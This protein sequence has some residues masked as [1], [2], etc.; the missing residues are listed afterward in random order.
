MPLSPKIARSILLPLRE[1]AMMPCA[2]T[3]LDVSFKNERTYHVN[4]HAVQPLM[5][6]GENP[7]CLLIESW[8]W[9]WDQVFREVPL[10]GPRV[11]GRSKIGAL[12]LIP[13]LSPSYGAYEGVAYIPNLEG[14]IDYLEDRTEGSHRGGGMGVD[15]K[16]HKYKITHP[17]TSVVSG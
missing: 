7:L 4:C 15:L 6:E 8:A 13:L 16:Y 5:Q 9:G 10:D 14:I 3:S 1:R 11:G 12:D 17:R 2:Y